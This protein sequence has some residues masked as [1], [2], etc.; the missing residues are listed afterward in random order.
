VSDFDPARRSA[1]QRAVAGTRALLLDLD[2]VLVMR[3][4]PIPGAAEAMARLDRAGFPYVVATN[5]SL[6]GRATLS[7]ELAKVGLDIPPGR[8]VCASSAAADW[9]RRR[10]PDRPLYVMGSTDALTE[11][12]GLELLSHD[13]AAAPGASAAAVVVGDAAD[14]FT[15]RN[16]QSAFTLV[17]NGARLVAMHR[18]RWWYTPEGAKLDS[19]GYVAALEF[20]TQ[21]RALVTGKPAAP[22]YR[23]GL[24]MLEALGEESAGA[25]ARKGRATPATRTGAASFRPA[26]VAMVGDDL[27]NDLRGAQRV[28]MKA[29]F[30]RSGKQGDA[31]LARFMAERAGRALDADAPSIVEIVDAL[32]A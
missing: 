31:D 16:I 5:T 23:A 9:C 18:N 20:S 26:D 8:I 6:V 4:E 28:G 1:L 24:R 15:P 3:N 13:G 7:A 11:F 27:W 21:K 25:P 14:D 10:F 32:P 2:G 30:V 19:G 22:F 17:R 29:F 12:A